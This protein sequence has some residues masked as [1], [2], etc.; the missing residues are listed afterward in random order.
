MP[1]T[2]IRTPLGQ[3]WTL[4]RASS[5]FLLPS[6]TACR[7]SFSKSA[8][9]AHHNDSS[10]SRFPRALTSICTQESFEF[11]KNAQIWPR[12]VSNTY[13]SFPISRRLIGCQ[14]SSILTLAAMMTPY[15]SSLATQARTLAKVWTSPTDT[16]S[17]SAS[18]WYTTPTPQLPPS[19][20]RPRRSRRPKPT[21]SFPLKMV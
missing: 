5:S 8:R 12:Q 3:P 20:L 16:L 21:D 14:R 19:E 9:Y 13:L 4:P 7:V 18:T 15:T 11:T 2:D 6:T 10:S 1:S 17:C